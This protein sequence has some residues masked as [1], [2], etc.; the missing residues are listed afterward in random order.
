MTDS[1][2]TLGRGGAGGT[3]T[4][5]DA[6][7]RVATGGHD[8]RAHADPVEEAPTREL[9][10]RIV[11]DFS[12][13]VDRQVELAKLEV[14]EDLDEAAGDLKSATIGGGIALGAGLLLTIWAWTGVIWLLNWVGAMFGVPYVGWIVGFVVPLIVAFVAWKAFIQPGL[15]VTKLR[16]L[17][18]T[19][20][21][22]K[23]DLEWL[24][25][26]KTPNAK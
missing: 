21:T 16:P 24:K 19:R 17:A 14:K 11:N 9:V 15:R 8:D 7:E 10:G 3:A 23:E 6:Y 12:G 20:E 1:Q 2:M 5:E 18:R 26:L 13:L 4:L 25:Q 22:L